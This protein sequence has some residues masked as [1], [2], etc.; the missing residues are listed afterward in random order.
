MSD[1]AIVAV[2]NALR[3][4]LNEK[5]GQG[6]DSIAGVD[7]ST[8]PLDKAQDDQKSSLNLFL[9]NISINGAWRNMD[10]STW[11]RAG[12][13]GTPPLAI[14][15][16]YLLTAYDQSGQETRL[17]SQHIL[18][19]AM[20]ILQDNAVL[21]TSPHK[22][23]ESIR[24]TPQPLS[25]DEMSKLWTTFQTQ[26]RTSVAYQVSVVLIES[27][28]ESPTP[29]PVLQRGRDDSGVTSQPDLIPPVPTL[30]EIELPDKKPALHLSDKWAIK[31]YHLKG[32]ASSIVRLM[33]PRLDNP[34]EIISPPDQTDTQITLTL[35]DD[36]D[37]TSKFPPGL[38]H[39]SIAVPNGAEPRITNALPLPLAPKITGLAT[40][41]DNDTTTL[42]VTCE[43]DFLPDQQVTLFMGSKAFSQYN[44][45]TTSDG[46]EKRDTL[47]FE[48]IDVASGEY[49]IRLR[50]D[51][52]DSLP[53][54]DYKAV[55]LRFDD[56]Q[57]V[58][59]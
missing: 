34:I 38:Y 52:V 56:T 29:L 21:N 23:I 11:N 8:S 7:I 31:G 12:G 46:S 20:Q 41:S 48:K 44:F 53:V 59:I 22:Q 9:Y 55:P 2:T 47:I 5:I 40:Q 6:D 45:A 57:K 15:L 14:D 25:I 4:L 35:K 28:K 26:Y 24:I 49:L 27:K 50:V 18:G 19:R 42:T 36:P 54:A 30:T 3:N 58:T 10:P 32:S 13:Q 51:G 17:T 37:A 1:S 33:H 43:P 39:L 16:S